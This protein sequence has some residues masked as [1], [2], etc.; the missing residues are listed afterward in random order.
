[1][2]YSERWRAVGVLAADGR[3]LGAGWA[4][5][6]AFLDHVDHVFGVSEFRKKM[7][8]A[9]QAARTLARAASILGSWTA[10]SPAR[11]RRET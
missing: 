6:D 1:M 5:H 3:G 4:H 11:G 10:A 8:F 7:W 2:R 9:L